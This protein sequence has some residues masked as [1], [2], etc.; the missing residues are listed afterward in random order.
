[1]SIDLQ[2]QE[3]MRAQEDEKV[4]SDTAKTTIASANATTAVDARRNRI[5][6]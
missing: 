1:M 2:P 4:T 5:G 3:G 6:A